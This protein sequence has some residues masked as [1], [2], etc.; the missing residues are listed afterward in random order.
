MSATPTVSVAATG[1]EKDQK[2]DMQDQELALHLPAW[3]PARPDLYRSKFSTWP[4]RSIVALGGLCCVGVAARSS[5]DERHA[6]CGHGARE[7]PDDV[8]PQMAEVA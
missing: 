1:D 7:R 8:Q 2:D 5:Q 3:P 6:D 4:G